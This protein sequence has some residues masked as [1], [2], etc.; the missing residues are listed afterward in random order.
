MPAGAPNSVGLVCLA[1]VVS[2]W[3]F[4]GL[5][6]DDTGAPST[7]EPMRPKF[8]FR[9]SF[10]AVKPLK[11]GAW[12]D[13]HLM[14]T[15]E[16]RARTFDAAFTNRDRAS[17]ARLRRKIR[18]AVRQNRTLIIGSVGGSFSAGLATFPARLVALLNTQPGT[19]LAPSEGG[20]GVSF[21]SIAQGS[22]SFELPLYCGPTVYAMRASGS[23]AGAP[24]RAMPPVPPDVWIV[25]FA[26]NWPDD[27]QAGDHF[28]GFLAANLH[29]PERSGAGEHAAAVINAV[30][31]P[32]LALAHVATGERFPA[33]NVWK[34]IYST[35]KKACDNLGVPIVSFLHGVLGSIEDTGFLESGEPTTAAA[36]IVNRTRQLYM[37]NGSNLHYSQ[38]S[39]RLHAELLFDLFRLAATSDGEDERPE[40]S[41]S[42]ALE[43][44]FTESTRSTVSR[45]VGSPDQPKTLNCMT[46]LNQGGNAMRPLAMKQF[47]LRTHYLEEG[48]PDAKRTFVPLASDAALILGIRINR[49]AKTACPIVYGYANETVRVSFPGLKTKDCFVTAWHTVGWGKLIPLYAARCRCE[50]PR[51]LADGKEHGIQF[52]PGAGLAQIAGIAVY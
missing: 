19:G 31:A 51:E 9:M 7:L 20:P 29:D 44:I 42:E 41:L 25:D 13:E 32:Q 49:G 33:L 11:H 26:A 27:S 48:R 45:I 5:Y 16:R 24:P 47:E 35:Q 30:V 40:P 22:S 3:C 12:D 43:A 14:D 37:S 21:I 34:Q 39:H 6:S 52:E 38:Y 23:P 17:L 18:N 15:P 10:L 2:L 46:L 36:K 50:I 4:G 28:T 1:L 8:P